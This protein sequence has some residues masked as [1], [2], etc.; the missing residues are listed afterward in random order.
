MQITASM[1]S[2]GHCCDVQDIWALHPAVMCSSHSQQ[3]SRHQ[4]WNVCSA[5]LMEDV[6][7]TGLRMA[8]GTFDQSRRAG[9][10]AARSH[11]SRFP[12]LVSAEGPGALWMLT[13]CT[14]LVHQ[15]CRSACKGSN[16]T[17]QPPTISF[18]LVLA[19]GSTPQHTACP[20]PWSAVKKFMPKDL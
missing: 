5:S 17:S 9:A 11:S 6:L 13:H 2:A 10:N 20:W 18:N 16:D 12:S 15:A 3:W 19:C 4:L 8:R 7:T 1:L 14:E